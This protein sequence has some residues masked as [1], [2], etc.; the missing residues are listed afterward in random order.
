MRMTGKE[1]HVI[2]VHL[3]EIGLANCESYITHIL[4]NVEPSRQLLLYN[5]Y[6]I[7]V[8]VLL[9][10]RDG[11]NRVVLFSNTEKNLKIRGQTS[12]ILTKNLLMSE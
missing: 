3:E 5:L 12:Q 11:W 9:E 1:S 7:I 2:S 8:A 6:C 4:G 10:E